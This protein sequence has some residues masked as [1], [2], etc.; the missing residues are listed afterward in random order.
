MNKTLLLGYLDGRRRPIADDPQAGE[1]HRALLAQAPELCLDLLADRAAHV[2]QRREVL[3]NLTGRPDTNGANREAILERLRAQPLEE[4]LAILEAIRSGRRNGRAARSLGLSFLL[5]HD[6]FAELASTR[7]TRLAR[8]FKH[9]LGE[10]TWSSVGRCLRPDAVNTANRRKRPGLFPA[11]LLE[12]LLSGKQAEPKKIADPEA[13]LHRTVLRY[14]KNPTAARESLRVLAGEV[15]EPLDP[16]LAKRMAAR[17]DLEQGAK[18]PRETLFGLRG[19]F[20]A[21]VPAARV[22]YLAAAVAGDDLSPRDGPL[23]VLF[24]QSLAPGCEPATPETVSKQVDKAAAGMPA[25]D[26][27]VALVLDL[28]GSAASSGERANHPAAIGLA[29]TALLRDRVSEVRLKQVGGSETLNGSAVTRPAGATDLASAVLAAARENPEA[30]LICTDGFENSR[31]GDTAA[32]VDGLRRLGVGLPIFQVVPLFAASEDL[33]RRAL[34]KEITVLTI[35]H[36]T[37]IGELLARVWLTNAP[38]GLSANDIDCFRR[39]LV[40]S[41]RR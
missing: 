16:S 5:G 22:R 1:R 40:G 23:T 14:A 11:A 12:R 8:L 6:R 39:L 25:I 17:R 41:F 35:Q 9:L 32:V 3:L 27:T 13:F 15:F 36:E 34:G 30:I 26:T 20:H 29:L 28:S 18:L 10:R 4:G 7:R 38:A 2:S 31:Q 24:K 33:S 37:D 21:N 19:T